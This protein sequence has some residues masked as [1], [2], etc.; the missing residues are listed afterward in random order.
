MYLKSSL[1]V[2][3]EWESILNFN[4]TLLQLKEVAEIIQLDIDYWK[5]AF[6]H[7]RPN[8]K[9]AF[10]NSYVKSKLMKQRLKRNKVFILFIR[11]RE[12]YFNLPHRKQPCMGPQ[13]LTKRRQDGAVL[14]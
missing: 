13:Y 7:D 9:G 2:S 11:E 8:P 4:C 5:R 12:A 3:N 6:K 1:E 10:G 14:L